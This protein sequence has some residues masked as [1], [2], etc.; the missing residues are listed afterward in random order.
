[1]EVQKILV[2]RLSAV[3]DVIRTL[4][5]VKALKERCPSS[6]ITW[7]VEEPS[8]DFL[9]SQPEVDEI[10]LFPRKRW[11]Q[12]IRSPRAWWRTAK[13]MSQ[14]VKELR[15]RQFDV[16][17]DFH[18]IL[19]SGL[20]SLLSGSPRRIGF[21]WRSSKE[22]SSLFSNVKVEL[23]KAGVTR[24]QRGFYLL[25]GLGFDVPHTSG[26]LSIPHRDREYVD[27]FFSQLPVPPSRPL[28]VIHPGT[29]VNYRSKRWMP[30][31]YAQL[32]DRLT[33]EIQGTIVFTWGPGELPLVEEIRKTMMAAS[34]LAPPT[35]SL[36]QLGEVF[37]RCNL[38]IG[39]DTGPTL[40]ASMMGVPVVIIYGPTDP[41]LYEPVGK[42]TNVMKGV[43]CN[44]CR[45]RFCKEMTCL[46]KITVEDVLEAA[47][48]LL[49]GTK[50]KGQGG[51]VRAS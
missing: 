3:G 30:D 8:K 26:S 22:G 19:K 40:I 38:Y 15:R 27:S 1:M 2:L 17:L 11:T 32:A 41:F 14:L 35:E 37:K 16:V 46:E 33:R 13:E 44:P 10:V 5:A 45:K 7:V 50:E 39:G 47:R 28:I 48:N 51:V 43:G 20:L 25:K 23:P 29:S 49:A 24:Y 31:R 9:E 36:T 18:G 34:I 4:P 6:Q 42:H 21:G 12:G